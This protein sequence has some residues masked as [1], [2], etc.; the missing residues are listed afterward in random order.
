M[1]TLK[2]SSRQRRH[3]SILLQ[4]LGRARLPILRPWSLVRQFVRWYNQQFISLGR[5]EMDERMR[6]MLSCGF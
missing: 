4:L 6:L 3:E 1:E 5:S 2:Q